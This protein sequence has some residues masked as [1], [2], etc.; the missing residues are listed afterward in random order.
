MTPSKKRGAY[1][2][3]HCKWPAVCYSSNTITDLVT[4]KYVQCTNAILC[5]HQFVVEIGVARTIVPSRMPDP[6]YQIPLVQR[7]ANDIVVTRAGQ[8]HSHPDALA[9][10]VANGADKRPSHPMH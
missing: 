7:R 3:P 4:H 9:A 2:C 5:G 8:G 1:T 6:A 10:V